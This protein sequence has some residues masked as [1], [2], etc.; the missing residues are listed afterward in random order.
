MYNYLVNRAT[1]ARSWFMLAFLS[2]FT[3][4]AGMLQAQVSSNPTIAIIPGVT[5]EQYVSFGI[6]GTGNC[7]CTDGLTIRLKRGNT[8]VW[9]ANS[10][11]SPLVT[12]YYVDLGPGVNETW[13][14]EV[15]ETGR[16]CTVPAVRC[17]CAAGDQVSCSG[18]RT[19]SVPIY[20]LPL[21]APSDFTASQDEY[22]DRIN[23]SWTN[24]ISLDPSDFDY[25]IRRD[26]NIIATLP[27]SR[28]SYTDLNN[29]G[30]NNLIPGQDYDYTIQAKCKSWGNTSTTPL[31]GPVT[32]SMYDPGFSATDG[33]Y[34]NRVALEW[35]DLTTTS[36]D[37]D[38]IRIER[39]IPE[40]T[41]VWG[42]FRAYQYEE[43]AIVSKNA[44]AYND[45]DG[46]P[47]MVYSYRLT[48]LSDVDSWTPIYDLGHRKP[49][50][51][52]SG[53]VISTQGAGVPGVTITA[54]PTVSG[55][56]PYPPAVSIP[57]YSTTT[58]IA[59]EFELRDMFYY[60]SAQFVITATYGNHNITPSQVTRILDLNVSRHSALTFTDNT[61]YTVGGKVEYPATAGG[62][63]CG[64]AAVE[65]LVDGQSRGIKTNG[66]GEWRTSIVQNGTYIFTPVFLHHSFNQ[67]SQSVTINGNNT[68]INFTNTETDTLTIQVRN[69][70]GQP[71]PH[72]AKINVV[73]TGNS[74]CYNQSFYTDPQ[75]IIKLNNL[76]ARAYRVSVDSLNPPNTNI[77]DELQRAPVLIDLTVRDTI[78]Y[79]INDSTVISYDPD[80]TWLSNGQFII[81]QR[82]DQYQ[83]DKRTVT[84]DVKPRADF[85]Y[86]SPVNITA[87]FLGAGQ[88]GTNNVVLKQGE[89]YT[90][91]FTVQESFGTQCYVDSG[92][93]IV[94]DFISDQQKAVE[95]PI[96]NGLASYSFTAGSPNITN[97]YTKLLYAEP[98]IGNM[99]DNP[100][101]F[102]VFVEGARRK[103]VAMFQNPPTFRFLYCMT[104]RVMTAS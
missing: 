90:V 57:T 9:S 84:T 2:L 29:N 71:I 54:T 76:P 4:G 93:L 19:L 34:T 32:G 104:L 100:A 31:E 64:M 78:T 52:V 82:P 8:V 87:D 45:Q 44:K 86:L 59:G 67:A 30:S 83:V 55:V 68:N 3:L 18:R 73:S 97:P 41:V 47:G 46:I 74:G 22:D 63:A 75:G 66:N 80:T 14:L 99:R 103:R 27:G 49:N 7:P 38:D 43:I 21:R 10:P 56:W 96:R 20:T 79:E 15:E 51:V 102:W 85:V 91:E 12:N 92:K 40:L 35:K 42:S 23:L 89:L 33:E 81:T 58:N 65:I 25:I 28:T 53:K 24:N 98:E 48:P 77:L 5:S 13:V 16:A 50:G 70:C 95:L 94:Y 37:I 39:S 69:A 61:V 101:E 6:V 88:C 1:R 26:G 72:V 17:L 36:K 11:V 62:V 60:D